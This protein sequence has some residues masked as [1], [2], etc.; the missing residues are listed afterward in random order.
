MKTNASEDRRTGWDPAGGRARVFS[1]HESFAVRYGWLPKLYEWV[2][3]DPALFTSDERAILGLGLGRNMVKS[4]RFWGEALG[5]IQVSRD[6]SLVTS[7]ANL[8]LDEQTGLDPYLEDPGSLWR[9]HWR[10]AAH[11]GLGAWVVVF[12]E[13]ADPEITR[14]RL[15][16]QVQS[17][18]LTVRGP[19]TAG[20][21]TAHVD[22]LV[23]TY[24]RADDG[25][26]EDALGSP[27]QELGLLVSGTSGGKSVV[28]LT[29]GP[30]PELDLRSF[31]YALHDFWI[32]TAAGSRTLSVRS[33]MLDRRGPGSLLRLDEISLHALLSDLSDEVKGMALVEDGAGGMNLVGE[34]DITDELEKYAWPNR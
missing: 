11:A 17:R 15:V 31:A 27:F 23:R 12:Q 6:S 4:I 1:G 28:K 7:F 33:L 13:L 25:Q 5:L 26:Q 9:L 18:A 24:A 19:I 22:M 3:K 20:T 32:G 16:S 34:A 8:L 10:I 14:E 2:R 30:R 29:R 21:A